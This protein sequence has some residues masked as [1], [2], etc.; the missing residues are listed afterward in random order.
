[1]INFSIAEIVAANSTR[2][3]TQPENVSAK[4]DSRIGQAIVVRPRRK[5]CGLQTLEK[6]RNVIGISTR[7]RS[8]PPVTMLPPLHR[9]REAGHASL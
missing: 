4:S 8:R 1:M 5:F 7:G 2:A 3:P 6:S 9:G